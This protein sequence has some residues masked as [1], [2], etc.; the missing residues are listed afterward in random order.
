MSA[1]PPKADIA[2]RRLDVRF[3]PDSDIALAKKMIGIAWPRAMFEAA[4]FDRPKQLRR[5]P[6]IH[7]R[8]WKQSRWVALVG[9]ALF[10][11]RRDLRVASE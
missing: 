4:V 5:P 2:Q 3:V 6:H 1:L 9:H 10:D 7:C 11:H 8:K